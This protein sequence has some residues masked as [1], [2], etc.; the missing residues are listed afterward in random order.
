MKEVKHDDSVPSLKAEVMLAKSD[1]A[2]A[3]KALQQ[4]Y[5]DNDKHEFLDPSVAWEAGLPC[6]ELR[7]P[8]IKVPG[9]KF[10]CYE[11]L[12][13]NSTGES[14]TGKKLEFAWKQSPQYTWA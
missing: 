2:E 14:H 10:F 1:G 11:P 12:P 8:P 13:T 6:E 3:I 7:S 5:D 9:K 4:K